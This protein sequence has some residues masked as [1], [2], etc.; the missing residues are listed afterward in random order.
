MKKKIGIVTFHRAHN[1]G[2]MLQAWALQEAL[3]RIGYDAFCVECGGH[4]AQRQWPQCRNFKELLFYP[5]RFLNMLGISQLRHYRFARFAKKNIKEI[6]IDPRTDDFEKYVNAL[7]VGSDQVWNPNLILPS[8]PI[9]LLEQVKNIH[10]VSYAASFGVS[11]LQPEFVPRYREALSSFNSISV[12]EE[13]G[14]RIVKN[15]LG[16]EPEV[17]LDPTMLLTAADYEYIEARRLVN[18]KYICV[19]CPAESEELYC[20][21]KKIARKTGLKLINIQNGRSGWLGCHWGDWRATSPDRFLSLIKYSELVITD[22]FHATV[23]SILYGKPFLTYR[24]RINAKGSSRIE[25]LL[26]NVALSNHFVGSSYEF[27]SIESCSIDDI[28][29]KFRSCDKLRKNSLQFLKAALDKA[30]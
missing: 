3:L 26:K 14:A 6:S 5:V 30:I 13:A 17:V 8:M 27:S 1:S 25:T 19:Y 24:T 12:R 16:Y 7:I 4:Q 23:F 29:D 15:I 21:A 22:S 10:K 2:A 28:S 20:F 9:Y 18:G 11:D